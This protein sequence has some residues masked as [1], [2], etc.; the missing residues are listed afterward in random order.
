MKNTFL[1]TLVLIALMIIGF[2][3][4]NPVSFFTGQRQP[5]SFIQAVGGMKVDIKENHLVVR[6][7]VSGLK[8]VTTKPMTINSAMGVREM[9][10]SRLGSVLQLSVVTSAIEKGMTTECGS[11]DL[12]KYPAGPYSVVYLDPDGTTHAIETITIP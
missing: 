5:W 3:A 2:F 7:D 10:C 8:T 6:C 4:A 12:S 1:L 11:L 9:K